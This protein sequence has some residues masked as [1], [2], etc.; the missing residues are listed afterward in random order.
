MSA[1]R[2]IHE[3][4]EKFRKDGLQIVRHTNMPIDIQTKI[5]QYLY[6]M[7]VVDKITPS[8]RVSWDF[9]KSE[10]LKLLLAK[11]DDF[12]ILQIGHTDFTPQNLE[13][14][15]PY[16]LNCAYY[17]FPCLNCHYYVF[18]NI[19]SSMWKHP[20]NSNPKLPFRLGR[21]K[22]ITYSAFELI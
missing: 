12:G 17:R 3:I 22:P 9:G 16:C 14:Y 11:T 20:M 4:I 15:S 13:L 18:P 6:S 5:W 7:Y 19:E 2:F 1:D 21:I 8:V 10:Q